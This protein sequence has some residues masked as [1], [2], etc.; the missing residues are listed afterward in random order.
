MNQNE[1]EN[2]V[3]KQ[4]DSAQNDD[5]MNLVN[6]LFKIEKLLKI[7]KTLKRTKLLW[8]FLTTMLY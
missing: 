6:N 5:M 4:D 8:I 2:G 3:G 1:N 7:M